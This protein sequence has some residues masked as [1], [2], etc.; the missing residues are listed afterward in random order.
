MPSARSGVTFFRLDSDVP[1]DLTSPSVC[2]SGSEP[3][4]RTLRRTLCAA[5]VTLDE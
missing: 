5:L 2:A 1:F 3:L 4:A